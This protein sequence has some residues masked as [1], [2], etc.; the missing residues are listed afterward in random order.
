MTS[1]IQ[2]LQRSEKGV[3]IK[4]LRD[5]LE[6]SD[7]SI[8]RLRDT[9]SDFYFVDIESERDPDG[10]T[11]S[12]VWK[13][14]NKDFRLPV[15]IWLDDESWI[16]L[17]LMLGR[18]GLFKSKQQKE[19]EQKIKNAINST[20][21]GD[22]TRNVKTS[23]VKFTG[24]RDYSGMDA[25]LSSI[26]RCLRKNESARVT[27]RAAST[28]IE[29]KYE[30][31]P[32]TLVDHGGALYLICAVPKHDHKL[33]RLS[34]ERIISFVPTGKKFTIPSGY[35][36]EEHLGE[37]FGITVEEPMNVVVR[38]FGESAFYAQNREWGKNQT[39]VS[40]DESLL[41]SFTA[42]GKYE[43]MRWIL[44]CGKD[45]IAIE[46]PELVKMVKEEHAGLIARYN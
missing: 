11:N 1:F 33:I 25:M 35:D 45:A 5:R 23:Y 22:K 43:I 42:S 37:S 13:L 46:P 4:E 31:E 27:Y 44:S 30:I 21:I 14:G 26:G 16:M 34:V 9:V 6:M 7:R 36:P 17:Q 32:Y 20:Y 8:Y 28:E 24:A 39:I 40:E 41:L 19:I 10:A 18:S 3:P 2:L 38:L 29:K 15:P 12:V